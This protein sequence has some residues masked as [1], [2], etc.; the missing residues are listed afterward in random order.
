MLSW[1]ISAG[2]VRCSVCESGPDE[3][4]RRQHH[5]RKQLTADADQGLLSMWQRCRDW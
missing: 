4:R 1:L 2:C 3:R 5:E